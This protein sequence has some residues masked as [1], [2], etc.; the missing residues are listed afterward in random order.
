M[1][2]SQVNQIA[3][4]YINDENFGAIENQ[5]SLW[6]FYNLLTG[7]LKSSYIDGFLDRSVNATEIATGI[8][9]SLHGED[10]YKWFI[11]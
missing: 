10:R 5:I 9:A 7:A 1:T 2:D 3:R 8:N 4:A 11:D 6:N